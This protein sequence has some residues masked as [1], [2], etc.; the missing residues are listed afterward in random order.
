MG[1]EGQAFFLQSPPSAVSL[2]HTLLMPLTSEVS[3]FNP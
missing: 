2:S 3:Y 1:N